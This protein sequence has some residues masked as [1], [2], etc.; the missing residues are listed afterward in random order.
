[1]A[2]LTT[3]IKQ[4]VPLDPIDINIAAGKTLGLSGLYNLSVTITQ[5]GGGTGTVQLSLTLTIAETALYQFENGSSTKSFS[6]TLNG[7]SGIFHPNFQLANLLPLT[8]P[9]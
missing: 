2:Y 8:V 5:V 7:N 6:F 9:P 1:M 3:T 4:I